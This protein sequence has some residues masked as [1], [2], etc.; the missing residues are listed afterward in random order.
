MFD[1]DDDSRRRRDADLARLSSMLEMLRAYQPLGGDSVADEVDDCADQVRTEDDDHAAAVDAIVVSSSWDELSCLPS[2]EE[3]TRAYTAVT[4]YGGAVFDAGAT[5]SG[6]HHGDEITASAEDSG[7]DGEAHEQ[8][9]QPSSSSLLPSGEEVFVPR[10]GTTYD[11]VGGA[12]SGP[13]YYVPDLLSAE[14]L[15]AVW[16]SYDVGANS[17]SFY[18]HRDELS[19]DAGSESLEQRI[20]HAQVQQGGAERTP[21][22]LE[23][24]TLLLQGNNNSK[25]TNSRRKDGS[26]RSCYSSTQRRG[27]A[28]TESRGDLPDLATSVGAPENHE[29]GDGTSAGSGGDLPDL[30]A[31]VGA[32]EIHEHGDRAEVAS[33]EDATCVICLEDY[34]EGEYTSTMPCS[35][36]HRFHEACLHTWFK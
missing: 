16:F 21:E 19:P 24:A 15:D 17:S 9:V 23:M 22:P 5:S 32:L 4:A 26:I 35:F 29:H 27:G 8:I 18:N 10:V 7:G 14:Q 6:M 34:K 31:S 28:N 3:F 25:S 30:A 1:V 2:Q 33:N 36:R 20:V 12:S 11:G 13:Y